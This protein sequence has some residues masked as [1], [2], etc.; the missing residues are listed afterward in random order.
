MN[1]AGAP[2]GSLVCVGL[3][4]MLGAHLLPRTRSQIEQADVVF[5]AASDAVVEL[6]VQE[7]RPDARSLQPYYA[8]GKS[9][10]RTYREM[11]DALLAEVRKGR[12]VCAAFYGHPGVFAQVTHDAIAAARAGGHDATMEPGVSAA[13]C[14]Y[15]DIGI[16][17]GRTGCQHYEASQFLFYRRRIDPSALLVLWQ[18]G[19][20]GDRGCTRYATGAAHRALLVERL[21]EDYPADHE[22]IVYEAATLPIAAARIERVRLDELPQAELHMHSTLVVPAC[23]PLVHDAR[24]LARLERI[25]AAEPGFPRTKLTLVKA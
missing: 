17:P 6:W 22:L 19:H 10:H 7:I 15:A 23:R 8:Q 2:Q 25:E 20:V 11:V 3:G 12:R 16:D 14:L 1:A 21:R 5:V 13:D 9:R 4:M 24:V 18:I